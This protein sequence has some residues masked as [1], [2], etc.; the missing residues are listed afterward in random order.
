[1]KIRVILISSGLLLILAGN[2]SAVSTIWTNADPSGNEWEKPSNWDA[3]VP[4]NGDNVIIDN[5]GL[6]G[7]YI[8]SAINAN[9]DTVDI[10]LNNGF[11][12]LVIDNGT[13]NSSSYIKI[14]INSGGSGTVTISPDSSS[15]DTW[16]TMQSWVVEVG[17]NGTGTLINLGGTIKIWSEWF[18]IAAWAGNGHVQLDGGTILSEGLHM[19]SGGSIDITGGTL[20]I[21]NDYVNHP[22]WRDIIAGW[23]WD[24]RLTAYNGIGTVLYDY[25]VTNLGAT[26]IT[27]TACA[28]PVGDMNRDC[29]VDFLDFVIVANNWL[30]DTRGL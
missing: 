7:A 20:I 12:E 2:A 15:P 21:N 30:V 1:V 23:I 6:T 17:V 27:A 10:G 13:L 22:T 18:N 14:G 26:T 19:G 29:V 4:A 11:C 8:G 9:C 24:G 5:G 28:R 16:V 3:G 25:N